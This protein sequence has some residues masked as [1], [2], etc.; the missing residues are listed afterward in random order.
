MNGI[1]CQLTRKRNKIHTKAKITNNPQHWNSK[2][3][4]RNRV[5]EEIRKHVKTIT[6]NIIFDS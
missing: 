3:Q 1:I 4:L 6:K 5:I 2:R